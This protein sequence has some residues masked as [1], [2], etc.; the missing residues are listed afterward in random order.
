MKRLY[1]L[2]IV[3]L[4][5]ACSVAKT[6]DNPDYKDL[7][8]LKPGNERA[9]IIAELGPPIAT[10]EEN[11]Q[12]VDIFKFK[13]GAHGGTKAAKAVG[14]TLVGIATLGVSELLLWPTETYA[15]AG[16]EMQIKAVYNK[17]YRLDHIK[18]LKD[19]RWL[20]LDELKDEAE[21]EK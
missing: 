10:I 15:G 17:D 11:G 14:Y 3:F 8:I 12:Q 21:A 16:A 5:Q 19:E 4:L 18:V 1:T 6:M 20:K 2:A 7:S 13:Q 9:A